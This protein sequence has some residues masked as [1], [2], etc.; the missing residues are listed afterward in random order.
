MSDESPGWAAIDDA[1]AEIYGEVEPL[2]FAAE[3]PMAVGG[4]DPLHGVSAW[5]STF[6]GR[7]CW[8]FVTYGYTELFEKESDDPAVSGFGFEMTPRA[9]CIRGRRGGP[10]CR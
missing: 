5:R 9:A 3:L 8:H 10:R 2:H 7:A 1:L 6:G 4:N